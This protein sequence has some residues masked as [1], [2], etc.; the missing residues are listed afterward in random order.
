MEPLQIYKGHTA[1]V[2]VRQLIPT[3]PPARADRPPRRQ[4]QDVAWHCLQENIFA[5]VGDDRK[6]LLS[7][8]SLSQ[9]APE[10]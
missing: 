10:T 2:E 9:F 1:I 4:K 8:L 3:S 7:V 5:S 6:L